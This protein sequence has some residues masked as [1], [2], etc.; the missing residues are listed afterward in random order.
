MKT[1]R[2]AS[3]IDS[4]WGNPILEAEEGG[5]EDRLIMK[6]QLH[7]ALCCSYEGRALPLTQ[8]EPVFPRVIPA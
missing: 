4:N 8:T 3:D 6:P 2:F 1:Q 5:R 7:S